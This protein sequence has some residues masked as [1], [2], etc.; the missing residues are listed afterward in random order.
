MVTPTDRL[1]DLHFKLSY[2]SKVDPS[3]DILGAFLVPVLSRATTY[4]RS[5]GYFS[6]SLLSSAAAGLSHFIHNGGTIRLLVG[7]QVF[8]HDVKA[9]TGAIAVEESFGERLATELVPA[10]EIELKRLEVIAWLMKEGRLEVRVGIPI[11]RHGEPIV[12]APLPYWHE[13]IGF[14]QDAYG[15]GVAFTG[16]VNDSLT[17][18]EINKEDCTVF[19]SWKAAD[20]YQNKVDSFEKKWKG[21]VHDFAVIALPEA[22]KRKLLT[23]AP[24]EAPPRRDILE[25][26]ANHAQIA[27]VLNLA[28]QLPNAQALAEATV[29]TTLQPHQR[30]V[31]YRLAD[32]YPRSWIVADEVGLGKTISAGMSLRRL[33]ISGRVNRVLILAPAN[34]C[35]NW[36]DEMFEKFGLWIPRLKNRILLGAHPSLD[37][38]LAPEENPFLTADTM[39]VSSQF[40]R[41]RT[42]QELLLKAASTHPYDLIILDEAHHASMRENDDEPTLLLRLLQNLNQRSATRALWLLTATPLQVHPIQ[43]FKLLQQVGL[44]KPFDDYAIFERYYTELTRPAGPNWEWLHGKLC[45]FKRPPDLDEQAYLL[46]LSNT[47][48]TSEVEGIRSFG[49]RHRKLEDTVYSPAFSQR[50]KEALRTW[51]RIRGPVERH[52][53]RHT[54]ETLRQYQREGRLNTTL[55][56]RDVATQPIM[57]RPEELA[58]QQ[59]L[60]GFIGRLAEAHGNSNQ[61]RFILSI[62]QQRLTSSWAAIE[63]SLTRRLNNEPLP[64]DDE[65][66]DADPTGASELGTVDHVALIPLTISEIREIRDYVKDLNTLQ[67]GDSKFEAL[68]SCVKEARDSSQRIIIFTQYTDTLAYLR[69]KLVGTYGT[70]LATYAGEGGRYYKDDAWMPVSKD[71]LVNRIR[72]GDVEILLAT[73]AA[74]EGLNLQSCSYLVNYDMPWNPMRAEQRIGRID[75]LGQVRASVTIRNFFVSELER[76]VYRALADRI[77]DF[78]RFIGGLPPILGV[79]EDGFIRNPL[80][81]SARLPELVDS[82]PE[83]TYEESPVMY[84]DFTRLVRDELAITLPAGGGASTITWEPSRVS[85]E[86][87]SW[88]ALA[89]YGHPKIMATL[90]KLAAGAIEPLAV[91]SNAQAGI[92]AITRADRLPAEQLRTIRT[93]DELD[94]VVD[95]V[96]AQNLASRILQAAVAKYDKYCEL[97]MQLQNQNSR[98]ALKNDYIR[99]VRTLVDLRVRLSLTDTGLLIDPT[100]AW[101]RFQEEETKNGSQL[102]YLAGLCGVLGFQRDDITSGQS[103]YVQPITERVYRRQLNDLE[104]LGAHIFRTWRRLGVTKPNRSSGTSP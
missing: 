72:R 32:L 14:M 24:P 15:D 57:F 77:I 63:S 27:T 49:T 89:T 88:R 66:E 55:A 59:K 35:S 68:R 11:D 87:G 36:Q 22:A 42:N 48:T 61:A 25:P 17:A 82:L 86:E 39:I 90:R 92:A 51:L 9:I 23:F 20:Y 102:P 30:Q 3:L 56:Y 64:V 69:G 4:A 100:E 46:S 83:P 81:E 76:R 7:A 70:L 44:G 101:K 96:G 21:E 6:S 73:D 99:L 2:E 84:G 91:A 95:L 29:G 52:V 78:N 71:E 26:R 18:L 16:S 62:Y 37:K 98:D 47:L 31:F 50:A 93:L 74:A 13:K 19:P 10:D 67:D 75:R 53:T 5:V 28:P 65:E 79:V 38:K 85:R 58:L 40:A 104:P 80:D 12:K 103:G 1:R 54:R 60:E 34:T 97:Q 45:S 33:F 94:D 8:E 41:L 43:L